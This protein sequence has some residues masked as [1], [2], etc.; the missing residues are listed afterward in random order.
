[1]ELITL[2]FLISEILM[3]LYQLLFYAENPFDRKRKYYLIFLFLFIL[4]NIFGGL[5]PD[6]HQNLS[7]FLQNILAYGSG[8][9]V[10]CYFPYYFYKAYGLPSLRF[11]AYYGIAIFLILPFTLFIGGEYFITGNLRASVEHAVVIPFIYAVFALNAIFRAVKLKYHED[12][13]HRSEMVLMYISI[14][15][16][17]FMPML[18]AVNVDQ[19][20]EV[21][22]MNSGFVIIS[23]LFFWKTVQQIRKNNQLLISLLNDKKPNNK[24]S[25]FNDNC[26]RYKLTAREIEVAN[27]VCKGLRYKEVADQLYISERTVT[28]HSQNIFLKVGVTTKFELVK[29][30]ELMNQQNFPVSS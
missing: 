20:L 19:F 18:S 12:K 27:L 24:E 21:L 5:Y 28:K 1:M 23:I 29:A 26:Y 10:A 16:W 17:G 22:I 13:T 3:F 25:I 6:P 30:L 11:H 15:P 14:L 9:A 7:I 8:F 2:I 4:Y